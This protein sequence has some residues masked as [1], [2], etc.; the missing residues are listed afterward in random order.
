MSK[1]FH[2]LTYESNLSADAPL[3]VSSDAATF[4]PGHQDGG[5]WDTAVLIDL[6]SNSEDSCK[7][8]NPISSLKSKC[9]YL[10]ETRM[11]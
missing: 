4:V 7:Y 9:L 8:E 2:P 5:P 1:R 6:F 10:K 3:S 11:A